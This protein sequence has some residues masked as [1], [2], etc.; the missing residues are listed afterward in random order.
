VGDLNG[1]LIV[2]EDDLQQL[3]SN[4][5]I[6]VGDLDGDGDVD[7]DDLDI[8]YASWGLCAG[9]PGFNPAADF[10]GD[11]CVTGRDQGFILGCFGT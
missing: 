2:D 5:G 8:F 1:D 11:G 10:D 9:E 3:E 4:L 6:H 7:N